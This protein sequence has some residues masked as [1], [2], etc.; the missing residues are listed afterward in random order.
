MGELRVQNSENVNCL[1]TVIHKNPINFVQY[2][3]LL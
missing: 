3:P 1:L 2:N